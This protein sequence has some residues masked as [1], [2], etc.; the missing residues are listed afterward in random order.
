MKV[1]TIGMTNTKQSQYCRGNAK[2]FGIQGFKFA[3]VVC[4]R[5]VRCLHHIAI[6]EAVALPLILL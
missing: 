5:G 4:P 3:V 1:I 6:E 2:A